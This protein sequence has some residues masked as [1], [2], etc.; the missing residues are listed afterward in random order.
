[1]I[2]S[3]SELEIG[4]VYFSEKGSRL[5]RENDSEVILGDHIIVP[6]PTRSPVGLAIEA[7]TGEKLTSGIFLMNATADGGGLVLFDPRT[8]PVGKGYLSVSN[9][10]IKRISTTLVEVRGGGGGW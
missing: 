9:I 1:M 7:A 6:I 8:L 4:K 3:A 5:V 10:T 2:S